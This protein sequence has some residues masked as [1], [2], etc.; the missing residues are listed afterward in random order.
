[1]KKGPQRTYTDLAIKALEAKHVLKKVDSQSKTPIT[2]HDIPTLNAPKT[3]DFSAIN[4][5]NVGKGDSMKNCQ[6]KSSYLVDE[7]KRVAS[8]S[9]PLRRA[10]SNVEKIGSPNKS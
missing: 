7:S 9:L 4:T 1:M 10:Q 6:P 5:S 3:V 2:S 8:S